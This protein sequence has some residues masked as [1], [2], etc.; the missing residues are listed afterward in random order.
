M[1]KILLGMAAASAM[2]IAT[3]ANALL[4]MNINE[5]TVGSES[6]YS[7][8]DDVL[9]DGFGSSPG[10][11][12]ASTT[13]A[14]FSVGA[15]TGTDSSLLSFPELFD[16]QAT[17]KGTGTALAPST[18]QI[19]LSETFLSGF[20]AAGFISSI[21][22]TG[23]PSNVSYQLFGGTS[24]DAFDISHLIA[25]GGATGFTGLHD[26]SSFITDPEFSLTLV[27]TFVSTSDSTTARL[28]S[29]D[30]LVV[31]EPS[32]LALFGLGL[33]GLGLVRRRA[34]K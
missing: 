26:F 31:P 27:A 20:D 33:L 22:T 21:T 1:N 6:S 3:S 12:A 34:Q 9:N 4:Y 25:S 29:T 10:L 18:L 24:N 30:T 8:I 7:A 32:I 23:D 13:T 11:L 14:H 5:T 19:L 16:L 17:V 2:F 15:G 28:Y